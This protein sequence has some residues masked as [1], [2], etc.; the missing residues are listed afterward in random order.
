MRPGFLRH[1]PRG[2]AAGPCNRWCPRFTKAGPPVSSCPRPT[3]T[4]SGTGSGTPKRNSSPPR[5]GR[6]PFAPGRGERAADHC[7]A[8]HRD[9]LAG[10]PRVALPQ[11]GLPVRHQRVGFVGTSVPSPNSCA[12]RELGET[13]FIAAAGWRATRCAAPPSSAS[14]A[15]PAARSDRRGR[16][17]PP[18][19]HRRR[20]TRCVRPARRGSRTARS[21]G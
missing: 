1:G 5:P 8:G 3:S 20:S 16:R 21:V 11:R 7:G 13:G 9:H 12:S 19:W 15:T 2:T 17:A 4:S 18:L 6:Q 14:R 10:T